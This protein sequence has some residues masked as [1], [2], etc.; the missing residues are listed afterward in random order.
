MAIS[1]SKNQK[2]SLTKSGSTLRKVFL[3]MGWDAV[4]PA[5]SG[6]FSRIF[7]GERENI[8]LDASCMMFDNSGNL[9]DFVW[10]NKL[11]SVCRSIIHSGD[12]LTGEGEG[13]DE[14]IHVDL[15][16]LP[17]TV[18]SLVFTI[19]SFRGQTFENVENAFVRLVDCD[20]KQEIARYNL[21]K[22]GP[23]TG[24]IMAIIRREGTDWTMEALG[25]PT[26]GRTVRDMVP[27]VTSMTSVSGL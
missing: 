2:V 11:R 8:D 9:I 20:T 17:R 6:I 26:N 16:A 25:I 27:A 1:L 21:S 7:G 3:G 23:Y 5:K 12:N 13:D 24:M 4:K 18:S 22:C 10:F 15:L 14:V 19:N